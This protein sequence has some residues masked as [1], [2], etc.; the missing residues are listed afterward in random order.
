MIRGITL[1]RK[2]TMPH[3]NGYAHE[4]TPLMGS[5]HVQHHHSNTYRFFLDLWYTPGMD[6]DKLLVKFPA[7]FWHIIKATLLRCK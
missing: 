7:Q 5:N 2:N 3:Q 4:G 6:S 1:P